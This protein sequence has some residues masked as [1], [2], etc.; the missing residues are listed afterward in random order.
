MEER[1]AGDGGFCVCERRG[2][3]VETEKGTRVCGDRGVCSVTER[4]WNTR[5]RGSVYVRREM[6]R[7][8]NAYVFSL[9]FVPANLLSM[10]LLSPKVLESG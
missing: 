3:E 2:R 9:F 7:K 10:S 8:E 1:E 5:V 6:A 4:G